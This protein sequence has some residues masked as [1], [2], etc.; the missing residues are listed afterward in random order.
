M[1]KGKNWYR[2]GKAAKEVPEVKRNHRATAV[3][4]KPNACVSQKSLLK[5]RLL[6]IQ[7][8][9]FDVI[10]LRWGYAF[11]FLKAP[12]GITYLIHC[13]S[14]MTTLSHRN[15]GYTRSMGKDLSIIPVYLWFFQDGSNHSG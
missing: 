3:T 12:C 6:G 15:P 11:L 4:P 13:I 5:H 14:F 7:G 8:R 10:G 2:A 9:F 1:K